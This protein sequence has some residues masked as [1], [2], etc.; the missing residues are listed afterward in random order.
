VV[1]AE[2]GAKKP[3]PAG[4]GMTMTS[5]RPTSPPGVSGRTAEATASG[6]S[7][8]MIPPGGIGSMG[9][10]TAALTH[11]VATA[12]GLDMSGKIAPVS[13]KG[14]KR[15]KLNLSYIAPL[16][17]MKIAFLVSVAMGI[18]FVLAVYILWT[19]LN[20]RHIFTQIDQMITDLIGQNRP[21]SLDI[22]KYVEQGRIMSG[23]TIIAVIDVI[24]FTVISALVAVIYNIIAALVGG[25]R[26]TLK[27]H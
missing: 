6:G 11:V 5:A 8:R 16:S 20:D 4:G 23:A 24:V 17:V 26:V 15:V 9:G 25:V 12:A 1:V 2:P 27:E 22:M 21:A 10:Q 3:P 13:S 19:V 14:N 7:G 18:A